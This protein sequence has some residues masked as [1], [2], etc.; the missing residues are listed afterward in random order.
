VRLHQ[1]V[2]V[3]H[4]AVQRSRHAEPLWSTLAYSVLSR[5]SA[6]AFAP[7]AKASAAAAKQVAKP[8]K[9]EE[10]VYEEPETDQWVQCS[11]CQQWRQVPDAFW[12]DIQV[13]WARSLRRCQPT[14]Q[15]L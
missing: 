14:A 7:A 8:V 2:C 10:V 9:Q 12:P 11:K 4:G 3:A 5:L 13:R 6:R 1:P 15:Q